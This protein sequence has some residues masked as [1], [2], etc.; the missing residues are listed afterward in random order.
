MAANRQPP[1][2][3]RTPGGHRPRRIA[4]SGEELGSEVVMGKGQSSEWFDSACSW[5]FP[6]EGL[7]EKAGPI[8]RK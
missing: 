2:N 6:V 3:R 7:V 1:G 5:A 4:P 8:G